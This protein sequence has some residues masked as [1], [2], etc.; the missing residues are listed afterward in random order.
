MTDSVQFDWERQ[1]RT[2]L[3]EVIFAAGKQAGQIASVLLEA[4]QREQSVL[5]TRLSP[6]L[7][8]LVIGQL[9][10]HLSAPPLVFHEASQTA[11]WGAPPPV[12]NGP[13]VGL[14]CA[15]TSDLPVA[16]EAQQTLTFLGCPSRL[17]ADVGVAGLWRLM[18]I[19]DELSQ[20]RALIAVA[21]M[22]GALFSV[23]AGLVPGIV[24]AVPSS[25]GYGVAQGGRAALS[26][27]LASC[28]PGVVCVNID[29]GFGAAA[30]AAKICQPQ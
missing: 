22:E 1:A 15:G 28:A 27:A 9:R 23:V 26:S 12:G 20:Y 10:A 24:I 3:P 7:F 11:V 6:A 13:G 5:L 16:L 25:V 30:A 8:E 18:D 17:Y 14:L 29:N 2:G 19:V 21:G 4:H